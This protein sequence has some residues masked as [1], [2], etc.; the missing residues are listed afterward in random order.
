M[1]KILALIAA[2][3]VFGIAAPS[4]S[5]AW[6]QCG[7]GYQPRVISHLPCGRP[8]YTAFQLCGYDHC[9]RPIGRWITQHTVC[10][11]S[12]CNPRS[13]CPPPPCAPSY[14]H[15]HSGYVPSYPGHHH[16]SGARF[17]FSFGR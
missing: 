14:G 9:G 4:V 5:Q 2:V 8:V 16:S 15:H 3:T 12:V 17:S 7:Q 1:K 6:D 10:G 13:Y 11:C